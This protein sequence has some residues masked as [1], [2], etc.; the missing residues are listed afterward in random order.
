M[1]KINQKLEQPIHQT[2]QPSEKESAVDA[3][4]FQ[5][6]INPVGTFHEGTYRF[7]FNLIEER[8]TFI[9]GLDNLIPD[10]RDERTKAEDAFNSKFDKSTSFP[11]L[12]QVLEPMQHRA[13]FDMEC[14][15]IVEFFRN[16]NSKES[17]AEDD[18][19]Y[20]CMGHGN[21]AEQVWPGFIL[22]S[23]Q[24]GK[25]VRAILIERSRYPAELAKED[26]VCF[27]A[28]RDLREQY[29]KYP[30]NNGQLY[31][32]WGQL[33]VNQFLCGI[34]GPDHIA[35][36]RMPFLAP[37]THRLYQRGLLQ[38]KNSSNWSKTEQV[39]ELEKNLFPYILAMLGKRKQ[40]VI[41]DHRGALDMKDPLLRTYNRFTQTWVKLFAD[42]YPKLAPNFTQRYPKGFN[43]QLYFLWGWEGINLM[44]NQPIALKDTQFMKNRGS[45]KSTAIWTAYPKGKGG[46]GSCE[47]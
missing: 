5:K 46:L 44:T 25:K 37:D 19:I 22:N 18:L 1:L 35:H 31:S 33:S 7:D 14:D 12:R 34:P 41:G 6:K 27:P 17:G 38:M 21:V 20:I 8:D 11:K 16:T 26:S 47:L 2:K 40:I 9:Q 10:L 24:N 43:K 23:L 13:R 30:L 3:G 45:I 39:R 29:A 4:L 32:H 15:R 42:K 28:S 36:D